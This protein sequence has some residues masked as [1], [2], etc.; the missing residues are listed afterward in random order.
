MS[1][2]LP[3]LAN[4]LA[5]RSTDPTRRAAVRATLEQSWPD[6]A[7]VGGWLLASRPLPRSRALTPECRARNL[8]FTEGAEQAQRSPGGLQGLADAVREGRYERLVSVPG[9]VGFLWLEDQ[10]LVAVRSA[11][12]RVPVYWWSSRGEVIVSSLLTEVAR[13]LDEVRMDPL[14][15]VLWASGNAMFFDRRTPLLGVRAAHPGEV[16]RIGASGSAS[17]HRWYDPWPEDLPRSRRGDVEERAARFGAAVR[18]TIEDELAPDGGNLLSLSGGVDSSSLAWLAARAGRPLAALSFIPRADDPAL[19]RERSFLDPLI[20]ELSIRPHW[21]RELS[22]LNRIEWLDGLPPVAVPVVHPVLCLLGEAAAA[23]ESSVLVG[24]EY[25]DEICGGELARYDLMR[26][27]S[28]AEMVGRLL[29]GGWRGTR[30][31]ARHRLGRLHLPSPYGTLPDIVAEHL[32]EEFAAGC[33]DRAR[34]LAESRKLHA[35]TLQ[36][37]DA[38]EGPVAQNWEVCSALSVRRT[39]PF[40]TRGVIDVVASC[41]PADLI[42]PTVKHLSRSAFRGAVPSRWLDRAD[43][44][45]FG[46]DPGSSI[47]VP[48]PL[49]SAVEGVLSPESLTRNPMVLGF[50][51][52][53]TVH[54]LLR[55]VGGSEGL[56]AGDAAGGP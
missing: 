11:A 27:A 8:A 33:E 26:T 46:A 14:L 2:D 19:A 10:E 25:C 47:E 36:I 53:L 20:D 1:V 4:V 56:R 43:R 42:S 50:R 35:F 12:G 28:G 24:G 52:G 5:F 17:V 44:G 30:S 7:E 15:A 23:M 3:P 21:T 41:R 49:L 48:G 54:T 31:W 45:H 18:Q 40:L 34:A 9:D 37:W 16:V 55:W 29:G 38:N 22:L 51:A 32:Q 6:V 39:M 13:V